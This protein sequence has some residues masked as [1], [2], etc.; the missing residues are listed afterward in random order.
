MSARLWLVQRY[1]AKNGA[2]GDFGECDGCIFKTVPTP[3][4]VVDIKTAELVTSDDR[5]EPYCAVVEGGVD[6][7]ECPA[8]DDEIRRENE[9][10]AAE[11]ESDRIL[12]REL[13]EAS[14]RR[15]K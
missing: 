8:L 9:A 10:N 3:A 2:Q 7:D 15:G 12:H 14:E 13:D 6:V 1:F 5:T 4:D 11:F